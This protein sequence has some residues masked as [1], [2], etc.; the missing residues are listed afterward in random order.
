MANFPRASI[1]S[2]LSG[3]DDTRGK[4]PF[5][6]QVLSID[7]ES[8]LLP[9]AMFLHINPTSLSM[10]Y[11]KN[12]DRFQTRGGWQEQHFGEQLLDISAE[13][14]TGAFINVDT[15]LA[16]LRR[17]DTIAYEKFEHLVQIF[18]NNGLVYDTK[19]NVQYRGRIRL[20]FEGGTYDGAFRSLSINES[21]TN[22]FNFTG[23]FSFRVEKEAINLL[24]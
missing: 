18:H 16:V 6:F 4:I 5:L 2:A 20:V 3:W 14:H 15:G 10:S 11:S 12:I 13:F 19:G 17:R 9:E 1:P 8:I 23:D 24:V 7:Y 22:P 21:A